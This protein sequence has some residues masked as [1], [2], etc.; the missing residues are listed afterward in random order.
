M[1]MQKNDKRKETKPKKKKK[2]S[3]IKTGKERDE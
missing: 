2:I 1:K 3:H